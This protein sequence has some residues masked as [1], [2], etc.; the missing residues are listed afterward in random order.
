MVESSGGYNQKRTYSQ[1]F[2]YIFVLFFTFFSYFKKNWPK[3]EEKQNFEGMLVLAQ[4]SGL[5]FQK[6]LGTPP[7]IT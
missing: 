6:I 2:F 1:N 3:S 5:L 4:A 7:N